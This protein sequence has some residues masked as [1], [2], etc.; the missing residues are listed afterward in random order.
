[1]IRYWK[2]SPF[3]H[4]VRFFLGVYRICLFSEVI[5]KAGANEDIDA[6]I[7]ASSKE[8]YSLEAMSISEP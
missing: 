3:E 2:E 7:E 8:S 4:N 1:M 6:G 5:N